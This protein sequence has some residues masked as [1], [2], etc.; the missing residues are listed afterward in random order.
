MRA[1]V[2][3]GG[4]LRAKPVVP[5]CTVSYRADPQKPLPLISSMT[6]AVMDAP[7]NVVR[8]CESVAQAIDV[9]MRASGSKNA[10]VAACVGLSENYVGKLRRG[11]RPLPSDTLKR[12]RFVAAFCLATG[13]KLL[14]Q[15]LALQSALEDDSTARLAA[16]LSQAAA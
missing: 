1:D 3:H 15:Y 11:E 16:L 9:A 13:S 14:R 10:Y 8:Q 12:E 4:H 2:V 7:A 5:S 6:R